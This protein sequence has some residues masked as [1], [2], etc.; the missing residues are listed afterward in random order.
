MTATGIFVSPAHSWSRPYLDIYTVPRTTWKKVWACFYYIRVAQNPGG[1]RTYAENGCYLSLWVVEPSSFFLSARK[2]KY[3]STDKWFGQMTSAVESFFPSHCHRYS[4]KWDENH[5]IAEIGHFWL[6]LGKLNPH[7]STHGWGRPNIFTKADYLTWSKYYYW[8]SFC[9]FSY[10]WVSWIPDGGCTT[11]KICN[12]HLLLRGK[13]P[14]P[15]IYPKEK[16]HLV[17]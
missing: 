9:L 10:T 5:E 12:F 4:Q 3:G 11:T 13:R 15:F 17:P 7:I 16:P 14:R 1:S 8:K 2:T 6:P